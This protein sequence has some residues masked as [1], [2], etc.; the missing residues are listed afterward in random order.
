[1]ISLTFLKPTRDQTLEKSK[2]IYCI[3]P[4]HPSS[5]DELKWNNVSHNQS[6]VK[7]DIIAQMLDPMDDS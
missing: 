1:M 2:S 3:A 6:L 7:K 5:E 4:Y